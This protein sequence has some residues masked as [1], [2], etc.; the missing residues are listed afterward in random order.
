MMTNLWSRAKQF[1]RLISLVVIV[2]VSWGIYRTVDHAWAQLSASGTS[3]FEWKLHPL[4]L[5]VSGLL[6]LLGV[7]PMAIFWY[8][9]LRAL[10]Q[11]PK[12]GETFRAFYIGGLGKYVPGK[13]L[14]V[15]L[16]TNLLR[17][18]RVSA[19]VAAVSVF[20]ETLTMMAVG[21]FLSILMMVFWMWDHLS[22][23]PY[24]FPLA[25][26]LLIVSALP[27]LPPICRYLVGRLGVEKLDREIKTQL[28]GL[29]F[30]LILSGW[31][32][33]TVGWVLLALSLW[34]V[35]E[36]INI[37][38]TDV[39]AHLP[40]FLAAVGMAIVVGFLSMIP[41]GAGVREYLL[42]IL[43]G[44]F[45]FEAVLHIPL[46]QATA[47]AAAVVLRLVWLIA[48]LILAGVFLPFGRRQRIA[49]TE[50]P[51]NNMPTE[52]VN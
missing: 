48:E 49:V 5:V 12:W 42:S 38:G 47:L 1:K 23:H 31:C 33:V 27:T 34:A 14:V 4:W 9:S 21:A 28:E 20:L 29:R 16:R 6:Y 25:V 51:E 17:S 24:L 52:P 44:T 37:P 50:A 43:L 40:Y 35:L 32:L 7:L 45:Y 18:E 46:P 41:G 2:V 15:V 11:H 26:A 39:L 13:V 8:L 10:G 3:G 19:T 22:S 30:S 36:A